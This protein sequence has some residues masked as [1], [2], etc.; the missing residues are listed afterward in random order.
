MKNIE[1]ISLPTKRKKKGVQCNLDQ[2]LL[3]AAR[4]E[5]RKEK[6]SITACLEWGLKVYLL[7]CNPRKA[8]EIGIR[9]EA[10]G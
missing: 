1:T 9:L 6:I 7:R 10:G 3:S 4:V 8:K 5:M 2:E